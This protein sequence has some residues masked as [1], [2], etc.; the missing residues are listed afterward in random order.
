MSEKMMRK[1]RQV[2]R[3]E[4]VNA[5]Q[6]IRWWKS[7]P[8]PMRNFEEFEVAVYQAAKRSRD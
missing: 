5:K 6:L 7:L 3:T 8:A 4:Q 1:L 2:A